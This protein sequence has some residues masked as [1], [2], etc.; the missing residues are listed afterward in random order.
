M[1]EII[2]N[3]NGTIDKYIGDAI[4]AFWGAP[5]ADKQQEANAVRAALEQ[6]EELKSINQKLQQQ[7]L[8]EV[9]IRIGIH[10]DKV[11]VGNIGGS[12][13]DYTAIGE[14]VN[15]TS[16][17]ES[18]NKFYQT[19]IICSEKTAKKLPTNLKVRLLDQVQVKG[20]LKATKIYQITSNQKSEF[21]RLNN[22]YQQ[23]FALFLNQKFKAAKE[24]LEKL[25]ND[26]PSKILLQRIEKIESG[27][28]SFNG[29]VR[30]F[31]FK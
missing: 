1:S 13:L 5:I 24:T 20:S 15:L 25:K 6:L 10:T 14:G 27:E 2:I 11:I 17:L 7:G 4:M 30:V 19:K 8:P 21:D 22:N 31:G 3:N 23:A 28:Q 16:R 29:G 18:L 9:E 26:Q 12:R